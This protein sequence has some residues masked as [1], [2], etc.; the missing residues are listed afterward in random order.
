MSRLI[1]KLDEEERLQPSDDGYIVYWTRRGGY[2]TAAHLR[3]IADELDRRNK[4]WHEQVMHGV[5]IPM[6]DTVC[7]D[8]QPD[9]RMPLSEYARVQKESM[10]KIKPLVWKKGIQS[11]FWAE[12]YADTVFGMFRI[13]HRKDDKY[14]I[15]AHPFARWQPT[16]FHE[17]DQA[18]EACQA[19]YERRVRECLE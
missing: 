5:G 9:W 7:T 18:K 15:A 3:E 13:I 10:P 17:I 8:F 11:D 2:L 19:E 14:A 12:S 4:T 6:P 16:S 1:G